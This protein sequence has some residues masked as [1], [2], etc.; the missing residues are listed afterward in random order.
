[1][2]SDTPSDTASRPD[3]PRDAPNQSLTPAEAVEEIVELRAEIDQLKQAVTSH[4]AVDQ[5]IGM[6]AT[7]GRV[8]P[9][10]GGAVLREVSQPTS[11]R[12]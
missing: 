7:L 6:M 1:M 10:E 12:P 8:P 5:A 9:D 2:T 4:A 3:E 11:G